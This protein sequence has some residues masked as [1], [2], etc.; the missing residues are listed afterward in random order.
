MRVGTHRGLVRANLRA[1]GGQRLRV[2]LR[3]VVPRHDLLPH[4]QPR[5]GLPPRVR[6]RRAPQQVTQLRVRLLP[7]LPQR[8]PLLHVPPPGV[9][10]PRA[11]HFLALLPH[12]PPLH[13]P[14]PREFPLRAPL[15][16][17]PPLLA[18][19]LHPLRS[20]GQPAPMPPH[21]LLPL[22]R[23]RPTLRAS[24]RHPATQPLAR[25]PP[26]R[27][28]PASLQPRQQRRAYADPDAKPPAAR[29][30]PRRSPPRCSNSSARC[31]R[32]SMWK[33]RAAMTGNGRRRRNADGRL[34]TVRS[35]R[36]RRGW[37]TTDAMF[38]QFHQHAVFQRKQLL[39]ARN[40]RTRLRCRLCG[41]VAAA[42]AAADAPSAAS[43]AEGWIAPDQTCAPLAGN[44][45]LRPCY[46]RAAPAAAELPGVAEL[47]SAVEL[48]VPETAGVA[49]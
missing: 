45:R 7:F 18:L 4:V 11:L 2:L 19:P 20:R 37:R 22:R 46:G 39:Q 8:G 23:S 30:T 40:L 1:V 9:R 16:R 24:N 3:R 47:A 26:Q 14:P 36:D 43:L 49:A 17:V 38:L 33:P 27:P 21:A 48:A 25:K 12:A 29:P 34:R 13:A 42:V 31:R 6:L 35:R 10:L 41:A 32:R 15:P 44:A 5:L 28:P